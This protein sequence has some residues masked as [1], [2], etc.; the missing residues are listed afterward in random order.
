MILL[1]CPGKG[2][3]FLFELFIVLLY[4]ATLHVAYLDSF[5]ADGGRMGEVLS[6][7]QIDHNSPLITINCESSKC[8]YSHESRTVSTLV[9]ISFE[10][11]RN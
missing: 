1:S 5:M 10:T 9:P 3:E 7:M 8:I 2:A 4:T 6:V 11:K